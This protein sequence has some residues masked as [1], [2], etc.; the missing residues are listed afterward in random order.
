[1]LSK[2]E[3]VKIVSFVDQ[4]DEYGQKRRRGSEE[5]ASE[6]FIKTY[7]QTNVNDPRYTNVTMIGLTKDKAI[8][9][10]NQIKYNN[11]VYDVLYVIPSARYYQVL[12]REA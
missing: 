6:M 7:S 2:L 12:M 11:L 9:V 5:R 3:K 4:V 10:N 8:T 1:M